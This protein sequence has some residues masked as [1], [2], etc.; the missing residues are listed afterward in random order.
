[1]GQN[2]WYQ[3]DP[4]GLYCMVQNSFPRGYLSDCGDRTRNLSPDLS[5]M[6]VLVTFGKTI[7]EACILGRDSLVKLG[8][9]HAVMGYVPNMFLMLLDKIDRDLFRVN[10]IMFSLCGCIRIVCPLIRAPARKG[11]AKRG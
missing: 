10:T 2:D 4:A 3:Q 6:G 11:G 1:M 8:I 5:Y 9:V 7:T